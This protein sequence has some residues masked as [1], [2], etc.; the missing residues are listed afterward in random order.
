[1]IQVSDNSC[2]EMVLFSKKKTTKQI[3]EKHN[4][5]QLNKQL[6]MIKHKNNKILSTCWFIYAFLR[7]E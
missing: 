4:V 2:R 5:V 7:I 1:M 3:E 6:Q